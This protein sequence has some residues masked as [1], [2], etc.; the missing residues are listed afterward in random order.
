MMD[1]PRATVMDGFCSRTTAQPSNTRCAISVTKGMCDAPPVST[2]ARQGSSRSSSMRF[3]VKKKPSQPV[4]QLNCPRMAPF[5]RTGKL[6]SPVTFSIN[7]SMSASGRPMRR[8][9]YLGVPRLVTPFGMRSP[10]SSVS[11]TVRLGSAY[12]PISPLK[13]IS[14]CVRRKYSRSYSCPS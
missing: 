3:I 2:T 6:S 10:S 11:Y 9:R 8:V 13:Y 14:F 4:S 1:S 12:S 5:S 7:S